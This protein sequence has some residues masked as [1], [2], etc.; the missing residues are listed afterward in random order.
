MSCNYVEACKARG[1]YLAPYS[2]A[3]PFPVPYQRFK[4]LVDRSFVLNS[5]SIYI[6]V[7]MLKGFKSLPGDTY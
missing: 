3:T 2:L 1:V 4:P 7:T 6:L 5:N